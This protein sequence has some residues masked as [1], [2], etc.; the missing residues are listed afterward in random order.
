MISQYLGQLVPELIQ[1]AEDLGMDSRA[2]DVVNI[3]Q[4][5][6]NPPPDYKGR[7]SMP[8]SQAASGDDADVISQ[9]LAAVC[10][11]NM[12][13]FCIILKYNDCVTHQ[14]KQTNKGRLRVFHYSVFHL[15]FATFL[16]QLLTL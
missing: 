16:S 5:T 1:V 15:I 9:K 13:D 7:I 10:K 3:P 4:N 11:Q 12:Q 6:Q 8:A 2:P 14:G